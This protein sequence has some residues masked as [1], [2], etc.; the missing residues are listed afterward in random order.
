MTGDLTGFG[1][2]TPESDIQLMTKPVDPN[3]IRRFIDNI[4]KAK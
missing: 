4:G 2:L 3:E 1:D